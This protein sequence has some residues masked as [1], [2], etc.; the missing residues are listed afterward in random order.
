MRLPIR[1]ILPSRKLLLLMACLLPAWLYLYLSFATGLFHLGY[2]GAEYLLDSQRVYL[3]WFRNSIPSFLETLYISRYYK[4]VLHP[5]LAVPL[6]FLTGGNPRAVVLLYSIVMCSL[7]AWAVLRI[8]RLF[9]PD[10]RAVLSCLVI[11]TLP[12]VLRVGPRFHSDL[13]ATALFMCGVATLWESALVG[14]KRPLWPA[15]IWFALSV[16]VRPAEGGLLLTL[17]LIGMYLAKVRSR[18]IVAV[19]V[20][21]GLAAAI[22][23]VPVVGKTLDWIWACTHS[24]RAAHDNAVPGAHSFVHYVSQLWAVYGGYII[25]PVV[26]PIPFLARN[27]KPLRKWFISVFLLM[28]VHPLIGFM[29]DNRDTRFYKTPGTMLWLTLLLALSSSQKKHWKQASAALLLLVTGLNLGIAFSDLLP[30]LPL[31]RLR[32]LAWP[33]VQYDELWVGY[34]QDLSAELMP[35]LYEKVDSAHAASVLVA[36]NAAIVMF[37][38]QLRANELRL[39]WK[40]DF[41]VA[42]AGDLKNSLLPYSHILLGPV[43]DREDRVPDPFGSPRLME[44]YHDWRV[45]RTLESGFQQTGFIQLWPD[46]WG[47]AMFQR[48]DLR[49]GPPT[50]FPA[51]GD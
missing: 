2:D 17:L 46:H 10:F 23:F 24:P 34:D 38:L 8:L 26:V 40:F 30:K 48:A 32:S 12:W 3:E 37:E 16:C 39:P 5:V 36:H 50:K 47:F 19:Y 51:W 21:A 49:P 9:I 43:S 4:G 11:M 13:P 27:L 18:R 1:S 6:F 25:I 35:L 28:L 29:S 44:L 33:P 42:D 20:L 22:W 15:A 7:L 41:G 45:G 14:W 31:T